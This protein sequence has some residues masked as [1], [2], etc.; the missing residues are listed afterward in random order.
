LEKLTSPQNIVMWNAA[1]E[2]WHTTWA[3][4][5]LRIDGEF[6]SGWKP[7]TEVWF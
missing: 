3:E 4:N 5:D 2:D 7:K 6:V 1:S